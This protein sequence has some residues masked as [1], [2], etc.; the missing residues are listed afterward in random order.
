MTQQTDD[1][2]NIEDEFAKLIAFRDNVIKNAVD[3]EWDTKTH[4]QINKLPNELQ[5]TIEDADL[6]KEYGGIC[7][8]GIKNLTPQQQA[9]LFRRWKID[10]K[11]S[12]QGLSR[13]KFQDFSKSVNGKYSYLGSP[14]YTEPSSVDKLPPGWEE[15][16][17]ED[18]T[19]TMFE[20]RL[21]AAQACLTEANVVMQQKNTFNENT[22]EYLK[23]VQPLL[24]LS[25]ST[26][27]QSNKTDT[28]N[29]AA[30]LL[31]T[32][33]QK[34]IDELRKEKIIKQEKAELEKSEEQVEDNDDQYQPELSR[35]V[36][37]NIPISTETK[38]I[39][40]LGGK[41]STLPPPPLSAPPP[42]PPPMLNQDKRYPKSKRNKRNQPLP[43][44]QH[45]LLFQQNQQLPNVPISSV[46]LQDNY[47]Q[48]LSN[49][50]QYPVANAPYSQYTPAIDYSGINFINTSRGSNPYNN[51]EDSDDVGYHY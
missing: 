50:N 38:N 24:N 23:Q 34:R 16:A 17:K 3:L 1:D 12:E 8:S 47:P 33:L 35:P 5:Y 7:V 51:Q 10:K 15:F 25:S 14:L 29:I 44:Y 36:L 30:D 42:P 20:S 37:R 21:L 28:S 6:F 22:S 18:K 46:N 19:S 31:R 11:I 9:R 26:E 48:I 2:Y 13:K 41:P 49:I 4:D 45:P 43:N 32:K 40:F 39:S 27:P